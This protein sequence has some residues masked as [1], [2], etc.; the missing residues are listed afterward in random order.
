M[1]TVWTW[2]AKDQVNSF[3]HIVQDD[4][5]NLRIV[6]RDDFH[7]SVANVPMAEAEEMVGALVN[8][9]F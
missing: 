1:R 3:L 9:L 5:D 8:E 6:L 7:V 4:D 2:Q